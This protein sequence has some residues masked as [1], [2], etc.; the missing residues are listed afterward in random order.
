VKLT[1]QDGIVSEDEQMTTIRY[2]NVDNLY[3]NDDYG[4]GNTIIIGIR[5]SSFN[6]PPEH[7]LRLRDKLRL[8]PAHT[9]DAGMRA[10][11]NSRTTAD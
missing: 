11:R 1:F 5:C 6:P 9:L 7:V 2:G 3:V 10:S 8:F 4:I